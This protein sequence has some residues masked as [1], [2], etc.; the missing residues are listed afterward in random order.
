MRACSGHPGD[1]IHLVRDRVVDVLANE[2]AGRGLVVA[3][4]APERAT[5]GELPVDRERQ[6]ALRA[7]ERPVSQHL[8]AVPHE[9]PLR[10]RLGAVD[11]PELGVRLTRIAGVYRQGLDG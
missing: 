7:D 8:H 9:P 5:E 2:V 3:E 10:A 1:E 6:R 4:T 11:A